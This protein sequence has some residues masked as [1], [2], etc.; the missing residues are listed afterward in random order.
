MFKKVGVVL[1][2]MDKMEIETELNGRIN[3]LE[4]SLKGL[5]DKIQET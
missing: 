5:M 3:F 4:K 1:I 2:K